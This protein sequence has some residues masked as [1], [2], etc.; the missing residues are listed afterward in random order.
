MYKYTLKNAKI[1]IKKSIFSEEINNLF[2]S[3]PKLNI[4]LLH[5]NFIIEWVLSNEVFFEKFEEI[6]ELISLTA[7]YIK[8][9]QNNTLFD[10]FF[11]NGGTHI[12]H[13]T[14]SEITNRNINRLKKV[15]EDLLSLTINGNKTKDFI[16]MIDDFI[17][18]PTSYIPEKVYYSCNVEPIRKYLRTKK[19]GTEQI[20]IYINY[21]QEYSF[22][23]T[24]NS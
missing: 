23:H 6:E 2:E 14:L 1:A 19:I 17:S 4:F 20:D 7:N 21:L 9:K 10:V 5:K 11:S 15:R 16:N 18:T 12:E 8:T 24:N 3:F 22:K 13:K